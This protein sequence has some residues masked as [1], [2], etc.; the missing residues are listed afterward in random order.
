MDFYS[1]LQGDS[2]GPLISVFREFVAL[3][4]YIKPCGSGQP[5]IF[6]KVYPYIDFIMA[7]IGSID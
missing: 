2:G 6:T 3:T 7:I 1:I 5:D 4:S